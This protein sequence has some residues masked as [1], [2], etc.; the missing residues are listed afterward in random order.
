MDLVLRSLAEDLEEEVEVVEHKGLGHPDTMCDA[1]AEGF[2]VALARFYLERFGRMM[3]FNVD[4]ALLVGGIS[5]PAFLGGRVLAPIEVFLAG[6][7]TCEAHGVRVP[8]EEIAREASR[9]WVRRNMHALHPDE[10]LLWRCLV[11]GGSSELVDVF[12]A[13]DVESGP[14]LANDTSMGAGYAPL[15]RL[16]RAVLA[17]SERLCALSRERPEVGEDTK[18]LGVR[19]REHVHLNVACALV[20][21][22]LSGMVD[23]TMRKLE[24]GQE[25]KTASEHVFGSEVAVE[26]NTADD[27]ASGRVYLTVTGTSAEAGDDGQVGRGNRVNGLIT[28]YRPMSLEAAAGKNPTSHVG[29]IYNVLAHR[30]ARE[31]T[32]SVHGVTAARCVLV[33][34]AG[35]PVGDPALV[36][37]RVRTRDGI[38]LEQVRRPIDAAVRAALAGL[39][40]LSNELLAKQISLY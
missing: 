37:L 18:I 9:A 2:G 20:D 16:E 38:P 21:R 1:F 28:P 23:Y 19:H 27:P 39:E 22:H 26:V 8:V 11:R 25:V 24:I 4:K 5:Q 35:R 34:R 10:H 40:A 12:S 31:L 6:R 33:G 13:H 32:A 17:A 3:H 15:S 7:A 36:D 30:I 29:K 14:W